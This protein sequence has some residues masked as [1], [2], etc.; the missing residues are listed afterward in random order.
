MKRQQ[1]FVTSS[2]YALFVESRSRGTSFS[3]SRNRESLAC[4]MN[5]RFKRRKK[6]KRAKEEEKT[7]S[8]VVHFKDLLFFSMSSLVFRYVYSYA[9]F[10]ISCLAL[11]LVEDL[12]NQLS[13]QRDARCGCNFVAVKSRWL[14]ATWRNTAIN[15]V[16]RGITCQGLVTYI[17]FVQLFCEVIL[18]INLSH[19]QFLSE[20]GYCSYIIL[21]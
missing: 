9:R 21:F 13:S 7:R 17:Q 14:S 1:R 4:M 10:A 2:I 16:P 5:K 3:N 19:L 20:Y 6:K 11:I 12:I 15:C 18:H 8:D